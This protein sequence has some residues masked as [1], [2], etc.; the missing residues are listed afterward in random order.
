MKA[1]F[2]TRLKNRIQSPKGNTNNLQ[3]CVAH[4]INVGKGQDREKKETAELERVFFRSRK[5]TEI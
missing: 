4:M 1:C 5:K 3:N 2:P